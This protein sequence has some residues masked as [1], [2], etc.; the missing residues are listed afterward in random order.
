MGISKT[1]LFLILYLS[2]KLFFTNSYISLPFSYINKKTGNSEISTSNMTEYFESLFNYG[3]YT[4]LN[5]NKKLIDFHL[6][7][8]RY[9]T[10]ISEKT[11]KEVDSKAADEK[12]ENGNLYSLEY[13]GISRAVLTNSSFSFKINNTNNFISCNLSFFMTKKMIN[14]LKDIKKYCYASENEE[15][16]LNINKGNKLS[17]VVIDYNPYDDDY[18]D[19]DDDYYEYND[20]ETEEN[21]IHTND[22]YY[23]EENSNLIY[24]LKSQKIISSYGIFIKYNNKNDENGQIILG[25]Y[26]HEYDPIH[27]NEND[28]KYYQILLEDNLPNWHIEFENVKYGEES[29]NYKQ[30]GEFSLDSGFI[31]TSISNKQYLD[32]IFFENSKYKDYC[33][34]KYIGDYIVKYC[35]EK[36]IKEFK[37]ITFYLPS[38]YN[39][40]SN[41]KDIFEFDYNDLFIR[42]NENNNYYFQIIFQSGYYRWLLGRPLFKKY[43]LVFDQN[44]KLFGFYESN[45]NN[46]VNNNVNNNEGKN[47]PLAWIL[48]IILFICLILVITISIICYMKLISEK[49]KKKA[50]ELIDDNYEYQPGDGNTNQTDNNQL[51]KDVKEE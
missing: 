25:G 14:N 23:L 3:I 15:I 38:I 36:I 47:F 28:F 24:Q 5:I 20:G 4:K 8:D 31:V 11:L 50:N 43:P 39:D 33:H 37:K 27:Y 21:K 42:S 29:L 6:T 51:Y 7:M 2:S 16:G 45:D 17:K 34:E 19:D 41:K 13:I 35:E 18:R 46:N 10:Y 49:R 40:D 9:A 48:V 12:N 32:S 1:F 26:P 30:I 44:K 22:G